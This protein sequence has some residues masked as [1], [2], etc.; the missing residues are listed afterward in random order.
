MSAFLQPQCTAGALG[1]AMGGIR[2]SVIPKVFVWGVHGLGGTF[3][4]GGTFP[5]WGNFGGEMHFALSLALVW[6]LRAT[7]AKFFHF[8]YVF[9]TFSVSNSPDPCR[10]SGFQCQ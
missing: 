2:Y 7:G 1:S 4:L 3:H 10:I 8:S 6:S 9:S 5:L